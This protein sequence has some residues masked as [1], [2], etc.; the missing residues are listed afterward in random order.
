MSALPAKSLT[1]RWAKTCMV[2]LGL[3]LVGGCQSYSRQWKEA[4]AQ[5]SSDP[6]EGRWEGSWVSDHNG[7]SGR[8]RCIISRG[9]NAVYRANFQ[10]K[11]AKTLTF[12]YV[13]SLQTLRE[14]ERISFNGE[15]RLGW[16]AGGLYRYVGHAEG[17]NFFCTYSNRYDFGTFRLLKQ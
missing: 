14:G 1:V 9:S 2:L 16:W 13:A 5:I 3:V 17:T 8:L 4:A 11:Y 7:H 6:F 15:A 10:A 12:H